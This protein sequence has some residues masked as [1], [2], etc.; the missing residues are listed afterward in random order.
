LLT[1]R[2]CLRWHA[3]L[4]RSFVSDFYYFLMTFETTRKYAKPFNWILTTLQTS[5]MAVG[6][7]VTV[8]SMNFGE[9]DSVA[10][11]NVLRTNSFLGLF[12]YASYFVLFLH[13]AIMSY[14]TKP[15]VASKD[16]EQQK[17]QQQRKGT[18]QDNPASIEKQPDEGK[19]SAVNTGSTRPRR[20][21][22]TP[23]KYDPS[24]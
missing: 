15:Q 10:P 4:L 12:M 6:I 19:S 3:L 9:N 21:L 17:P 2:R 14:C 23:Q 8:Q 5:Q 11:C 13:F 20:T 16:K 18:Q 22:K 24:E 1:T 7:F